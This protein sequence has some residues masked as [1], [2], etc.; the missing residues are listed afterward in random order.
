MTPYHLQF[1]GLIE[2]Q[3]RS[4]KASLRCHLQ[5]SK[6]WVDS[7]PFVLETR[8]SLKEDIGYSS[9]ELLYGSPHCLPGEFVSKISN[10]QYSKF[11]QGLQ[12]TIHDM[13]LSD[14]THGN[15]TVFLFKQLS[16][17]SHVFICNNADSSSLQPVYSG[18][19]AIK[20]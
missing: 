7:L 15:K 3:H 2:R 19:Y 13:K 12:R 6:S 4:V 5:Q 14:T 1:N 9:A 17:C 18:P 10:V 11:V 16:I 20:Q 8:T